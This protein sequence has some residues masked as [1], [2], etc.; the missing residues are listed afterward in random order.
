MNWTQTRVNLIA[1]GIDP[2]RL[3]EKWQRGIDLYEANLYEADLRGADLSGADLSG[4]DLRRADLY[5]ANL[6]EADLR[7]ADL[8]GADL[9]GADLSRA[10]LN[11]N[12][13]VLLAGIV[14]QVA[15]DDVSRRKLAGLI[16]IS[17]DWCWEKFISV[18]TGEEIDWLGGVFAPYAQDDNNAPDIV[19]QYI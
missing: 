10:I 4:A 14:Y 9:Y 1:A 3:P 8:S 5:E 7:G 18:L 13:H 2:A 16:L 11:W 12:S 6:Y 19:R 15:G 17:I